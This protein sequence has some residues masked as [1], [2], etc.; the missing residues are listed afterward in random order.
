MDIYKPYPF[1]EEEFKPEGSKEQ[2]HRIED[3]RESDVECPWYFSLLPDVEGSFVDVDA[4]KAIEGN[5]E[6]PNLL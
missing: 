1:I 6:I 4:C 3:Q 5:F 2:H